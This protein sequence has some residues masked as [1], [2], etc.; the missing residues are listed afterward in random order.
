NHLFSDRLFSNTSLIFSKYD[1]QIDIT[2]NAQTFSIISKIQDYNLKQD[3]EYTPSTSQTVRFGAQAIYHTITPGYVAVSSSDASVNPTAD[4]S[5]FSLE[6][7]AYLSHEWKATPRLDFTTGLR[8]SGFSLLGTGTY[9]TY[10]AA[11]TVTGSTTYDSRTQFLKT[12]LRLEPRFAASYQLSDA[13]TLKA[14]Y[15]RNVQNL[16]LLSNSST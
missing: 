7:A 11:G 1:Y 3:F 5:N 15:A 4:R 14:G 10:D 13:A 12:Y 6:T 8:L 16:H 9:K 2:T